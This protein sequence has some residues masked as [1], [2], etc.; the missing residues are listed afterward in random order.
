M[1]LIPVF[2][3]VIDISIKQ[4]TNSLYLNDPLNTA[5]INSPGKPGTR[6]IISMTNNGSI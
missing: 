6:P 4:Q 3:Y 1:H 5:A 2:F